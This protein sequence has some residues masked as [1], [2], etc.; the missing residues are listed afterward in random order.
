MLSELVGWMKS[1]FAAFLKHECK[2]LFQEHLPNRQGIMS[3]VGVSCLQTGSGSVLFGCILVNL[4]FHIGI[5]IAG[6]LS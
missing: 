4:F 3:N 5:P 1:G 6:C 2:L